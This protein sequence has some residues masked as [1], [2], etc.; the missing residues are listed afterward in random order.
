MLT[1]ASLM[2]LVL[3]WCDC[4]KGGECS[5]VRDLGSVN[6]VSD[7]NTIPLRVQGVLNQATLM[8]QA[9]T[10]A[11]ANVFSVSTAGAVVT[12]G[13]LSC[14][15]NLGDSGTSVT[16]DSLGVGTGSIG[17]SHVTAATVTI[18]N[19]AAGQVPVELKGT[20]SQSGNLLL[21]ETSAGVDKLTI[22]AGGTL[23][24][25]GDISVEDVYCE[26]FDVTGTLDAAAFTS[27]SASITSTA[28]TIT[29]MIRG[30]ASQAVNLM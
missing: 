9:I 6:I 11:D 15:G 10:H 17:T 22:S 25:D 5:V 29:V 30:H 2:L 20:T 18:I 4:L 21:I 7:A 27:H 16:V 3:L 12:T 26:A 1:W 24:V 23:T 14:G 13:G 19:D 28:N 8:V